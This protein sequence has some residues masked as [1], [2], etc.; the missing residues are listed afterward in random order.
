M[1]INIQKAKICFNIDD[2]TSYNN[3]ENAKKLKT[4]IKSYKSGE[5]LSWKIITMKMYD[6]Y[7]SI[8]ESI[9]EIN[10]IRSL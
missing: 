6:D 8:C 9:H 7:S 1:K 5:L 3:E 10:R 2:I 4:F